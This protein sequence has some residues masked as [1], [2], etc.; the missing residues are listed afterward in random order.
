MKRSDLYLRYFIILTI[1]ALVLFFSC[2]TKRDSDYHLQVPETFDSLPPIPGYNLLT[3]EK[4]KLGKLLFEDE[5][6][7]EDGRI[8]CASCHLEEYA[9]SDTVALSAGI[10]GK[11]DRRNAYGLVNVAYQKALFMEGG[12]PN[13]EL[14]ALAPFLNKNEMG[15]KL[16][17]AVKRVGETREYKDLSQKAFGT[18]SID[19]KIIAYSLAA[20]QRTLISSG[21]DYDA[22]ISGDSL[23]LNNSEQRGMDL[24]F[25]SKTQSS[26]CHSGFL[27]TDQ[28]YYNIGLDS[29]ITDEGRG[30]IS[31]SEGDLGKFK[32]PSLRN[33]AR[34]GPYM[35]DGRMG[36][37]KEVIEF[38]TSGGKDYPN[39][40]R[41][42]KPLNLSEN[43]KSDLIA[44]L[45]AL[46]DN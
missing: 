22:Y 8:S 24:F 25:S 2:Q 43:E 36:T 17:L 12:V 3:L 7:S 15:F 44:F 39:K 14:Q 35:H 34:T 41:R 42:I 11:R 6:L 37:L 40:D 20:F 5:R 9:Y 28:N 31:Q 13:L 27:F 33:V 21:S 45:K 23:A 4:V 26:S 16:N 19:A 1:G 46:D 29:V 10:H 32:T 38:Y 30:A 18:D